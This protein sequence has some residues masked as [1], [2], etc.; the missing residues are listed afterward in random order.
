MSNDKVYEIV[1][2]WR[3]A[4]ESEVSEK[5]PKKA[6]FIEVAIGFSVSM[7]LFH[8]FHHP[9]IATVV[10]CIVSLVAIGGLAIPPLYAGIKRGGM[11]LGKVLGGLV[12]WVLL[13]PFF[14]ICF[15]VGRIGLLF[16]RKDPMARRYNA[17]L[18]TYWTARKEIPDLEQYRK[19]Y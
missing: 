10:I 6:V 13:L 9:I 15:T 19:Q 14:Y 4:K 2:P 1:W 7:L 18:S 17:D 5:P 8:V 11:W 3:V 16:S 12:T